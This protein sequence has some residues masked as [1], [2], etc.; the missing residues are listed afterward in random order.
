METGKAMYT[1]VS[2]T[3]SDK[4]AEVRHA[5]LVNL[6]NGNTASAIILN[7]QVT[8]SGVVVSIDKKAAQQLGII[9]TGAAPVDIRYKQ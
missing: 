6:Q 3:D 4:T 5:K 8:R 9:Y 7:R 1:P 2:A